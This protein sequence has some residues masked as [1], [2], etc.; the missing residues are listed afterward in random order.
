MMIKHALPLFLILSGS[1]A[2]A[3]QW[4]LVAPIKTR[5]EFPGIRMVSDLVGYAID[6]QTD[7]TEA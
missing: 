3:Q 6:L 5:S 2:S 7:A 4:E 1:A